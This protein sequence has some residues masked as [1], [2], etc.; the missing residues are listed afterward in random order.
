MIYAVI[1]SFFWG[2]MYY[3]QSKLISKG[4]NPLSLVVKGYGSTKPLNDN[5][6]ENNRAKNRRVEIKAKK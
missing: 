5:S 2:T 1:A 6:T 4:M 3:F